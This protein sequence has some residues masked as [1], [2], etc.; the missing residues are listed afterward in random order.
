MS[1][2]HRTSRHP[3]IPA[4]KDIQNWNES[5]TS[6]VLTLSFRPEIAVHNIGFLNKKDLHH[7]NKIVLNLVEIEINCI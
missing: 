3:K 4:W 7:L 2:F 6:M 1:Q 5:A